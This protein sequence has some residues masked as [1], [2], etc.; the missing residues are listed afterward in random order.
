MS[1][2]ESEYFLNS[3]ND[4][5]SNEGE[6]RSTYPIND[7]LPEADNTLASCSSGGDSSDLAEENDAFGLTSSDMP[8]TAGCNR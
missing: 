5:V 1:F 6:D 8:V 7:T 3:S 4:E 2:F